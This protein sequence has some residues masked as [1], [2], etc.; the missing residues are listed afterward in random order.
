M[1]SKYL[2]KAIRVAYLN[3]RNCARLG[4]GGAI[5]ENGEIRSAQRLRVFRQELLGKDDIDSSVQQELLESGSDL[6]GNTI[7]ATESIPA[8]Y[9][10]CGFSFVRHQGLQIRSSIAPSGLTSSISSGI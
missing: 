5:D 10:H 4:D 8:R 1:M 2:G 9:N 3:C 7:V 6:P